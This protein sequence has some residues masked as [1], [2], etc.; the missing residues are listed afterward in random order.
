MSYFDSSACW[1]VNAWISTLQW[2]WNSDWWV[3]LLRDL[4]VTLRLAD[5]VTESVRCWVDLC[6][7]Q[8]PPSTM[9]FTH[10]KLFKNCGK[11]DIKW[12]V[13]FSLSKGAFQG[14][15]VH[16]LCCAAPALP[17]H[18]QNCFRLSELKLSAS[19]AIAPL[20]T[21]HPAP[22]LAAL[23]NCHP[24]IWLCESDYSRCLRYV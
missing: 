23:G 7:L 15:H 12:N 11:I 21:T 14:P 20:T 2:L 24:V 18:L 19:Q 9:K 3:S 13:P 8:H 16:S 5:M 17:V 1:N 6:S 22:T 4:R 10:F